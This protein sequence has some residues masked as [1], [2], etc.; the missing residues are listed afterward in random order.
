[1]SMR[2]TARLNDFGVRILEHVVE[3]GWGCTEQMFPEYP[4]VGVL[5]DGVSHFGDVRQGRATGT[6]LNQLDVGSR[7]WTVDVEWKWRGDA[8]EDAVRRVLPHMLSEPCDVHL[9]H[10]LWVDGTMRDAPK[11]L[12]LEPVPP[13]EPDWDEALPD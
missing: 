11:V 4:I 1:M 3:H 2:Y 6:R 10:D 12:L 13:P 9:C 5:S 8:T 7:T